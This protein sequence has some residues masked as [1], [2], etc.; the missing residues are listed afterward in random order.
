MISSTISE[1]T[2]IGHSGS[3]AVSQYLGILL[4]A[5]NQAHPRPGEVPRQKER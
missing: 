4:A 2:V 1:L 5:G 3:E